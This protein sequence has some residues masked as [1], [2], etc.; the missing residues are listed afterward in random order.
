[1]RLLLD[2]KTLIWWHDFPNKLP[3][4]VHTALQDDTSQIFISVASAWEMQIKTQLG[5]LSLSKPWDEIFE[6]EHRRN[7]FTFLVADRPHIRVLDQLPFHHR[8][9]FDRLLIA[10]AL[11]EGL[12]LVSN[13]G[14]FSSYPVPLLW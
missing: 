5:K 7:G 3:S 13:D 6:I 1:M 4:S 14:L 8:D 10:Q 2:T 9:P 11:H 12:T